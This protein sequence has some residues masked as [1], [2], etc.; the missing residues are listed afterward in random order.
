MYMKCEG[1]MERITEKKIIRL[2]RKQ[3]SEPIDFS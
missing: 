2:T 3:A 1:R